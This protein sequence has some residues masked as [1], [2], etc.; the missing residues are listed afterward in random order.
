MIMENNN[1]NRY[2]VIT[3]QYAIK[4]KLYIYISVWDGISPVGRLSRQNFGH[5]SML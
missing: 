4:K 5:Q 2:A 3:I 1:S